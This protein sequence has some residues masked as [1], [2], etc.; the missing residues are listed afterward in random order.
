M[1]RTPRITVAGLPLHIVQR[2]NNRQACFARRKDYETFLRLMDETSLSYGIHIHA[3]VLMTNHVHLLVTPIDEASASKMMQQLGRRYGLYFNKSHQRSGTLW[4]GRFRSSLIE[5][6]NYLL[7]CQRY[8]ELNPVR[9]GMV[10]CPSLYR[11]SSYR[12]NALGEPASL[13]T[14]HSVWMGLGRC[15]KERYENYRKLFADAV[16][17]RIFRHAC[18]KGL[19]VGSAGWQAGLESEHGVCFG[20]GKQGRPP[21]TPRK[22]I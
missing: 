18:Q 1:P 15:P 17:A 4:E 20:S 6:D 9:A 19:P 21:K 22:G 16:D 13:I 14:P 3:F 11:W 12:T 7:A 2:G 10:A 5:T 8:I